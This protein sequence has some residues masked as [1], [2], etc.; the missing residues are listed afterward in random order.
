MAEKRA[1]KLRKAA[2]D[3]LAAANA[4]VAIATDGTYFIE[5]AGLTDPER[6]ALLAPAHS[7]TLQRLLADRFLLQH[8]AESPAAAAT[9]RPGE[10]TSSQ[11]A[12]ESEGIDAAVLRE[13]IDRNG[14]KQK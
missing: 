1:A 3:K 7:E 11:S 13:W 9:E 5:T 4:M 10:V 2:W 6:I 8:T 12:K 14:G